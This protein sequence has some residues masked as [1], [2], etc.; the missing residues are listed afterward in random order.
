LLLLELLNHYFQT[1][2]SRSNYCL[3]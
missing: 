3:T 1:M 2:Y